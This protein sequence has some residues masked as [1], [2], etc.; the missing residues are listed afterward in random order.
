MRMPGF[1]AEAGSLPAQGHYRGVRVAASMAAGKLV[2]E[3]VAPWPPNGGM[4]PCRTSSCVTVG[5]CRT[6]VRCCRLF[7]SCICSTVPCPTT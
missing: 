3:L 2:A 6:S 4:W 7:G 5:S 1:T